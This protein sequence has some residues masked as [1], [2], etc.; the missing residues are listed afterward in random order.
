MLTSTIISLLAAAT[1]TI[2]TPV[3]PKLA[4]ENAPNTVLV[5]EL[6][7]SKTSTVRGS[8]TFTSP[9]D[10][11]GVDGAVV[12]KGLPK[13][14]GPFT[15]HIHA[16][17]V[18]GDGNCTATGGHFDP[19][20]AASQKDYKCDPK[21]PTLCEIGD[22][23]GKQGAITTSNGEFSAKYVDLPQTVYALY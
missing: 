1:V 19:Y 16:S 13:T 10:S 4:A 12:L 15:Y 14:G 20:E 9:K 8:I 22:L 23:S 11:V 21:K 5:A 17:T 2:A 7:E 6:P 3:E 18:P